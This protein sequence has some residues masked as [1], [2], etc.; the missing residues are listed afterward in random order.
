MTRIRP[1]AMALG[2]CVLPLL[3]GCAT[4]S[5]DAQLGTA[6]AVERDSAAPVT[7]TRSDR[8]TASGDI[9]VVV[10]MREALAERLA[11]SELSAADAGP[12][13]YRI[14]VT[15][16]DFRPDSTLARWLPPGIGATVIE[17]DGSVIDADRGSA[18]GGVRDERVVYLG[19]LY[20]E[21]AWREA[22]ARVADDI[23]STL[24]RGRGARA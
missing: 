8:G 20:S 9:D 11:A 13:P 1:A 7:V 6:P 12:A 19:G 23:V 24:E 21:D 2:L 14:A 17:V 5:A 15:V 10:L 3:A 4:P 18:M 16:T 22:F